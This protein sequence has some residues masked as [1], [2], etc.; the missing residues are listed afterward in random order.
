VDLAESRMFLPLSWMSGSASP[1]YCAERRTSIESSQHARAKGGDRN[2][3]EAL[4]REHARAIH[5]VCRFVAG[6][7]DARD[8]M[9]E[10]LERIV[11]SIDRFDPE[12]GSFRSWALTVARNVCRDRLR[13]RGLERRTFVDDGDAKT[14][15]TASAAPGP[16][17]VALARIE[18]ERLSHALETLPEPM[19]LA[20][21]LFHV[22]EATYEEIAS[23][24]EVPIGTVM[25]WL[26]RG[27]KR[28]RAALEEGETA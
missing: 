22:H 9:Q 15:W 23:T 10:S 7:D 4:L 6:N 28:L 24:L 14:D 5:D 1:A 17:R 16:D 3:L 18:S 8:A 19:R 13:R 12:R 21:L 26:H 11:V 25:T 20:V 27:R 2:A